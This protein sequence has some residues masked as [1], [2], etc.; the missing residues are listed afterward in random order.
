MRFYGGCDSFLVIYHRYGGQCA[1]VSLPDFTSPV[2]CATD[3][4]RRIGE[5]QRSS[6][7][8]RTGLIQAWEG[9]GPMLL[10]AGA[11]TPQHSLYLS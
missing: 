4:R 11:Q 2:H 7:D 9:L 10:A 1:T 8:I 6:S 3:I 5:K